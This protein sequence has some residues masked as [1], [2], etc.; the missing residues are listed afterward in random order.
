MLFM[1]KGGGR[2]YEL[3]FSNAGQ[4]VKGDQVA[5]AG[6]PIGSVKDV[7]LTDDGL[8]KITISSDR[9]LHEGTTAI[10]RATSLSGISNHYIAIEPGPNNRPELSEG[11]T[12]PADRTTTP[13]D[14]D[15]LFNTFTPGTRQALRE[16]INGSATLY[17]GNT[18]G[19]RATYKYLAP[20][21]SSTQRLF[22]ELTRDQSAF[23]QFLVNSADVLGA[24]ATRRDDLSSLVANANRSLGAIASQ[25]QALSN[26]LAALPPTLRQAN[27]TFVNL[28]L[29]LDKLDP[30]VAA[31]KPATKNLAPFL[32]KLRPVARR[33]V[34]V[35]ADLSRAVHR[36]GASNDLTDTLRGLPK[37]E[38][39][40]NN[41]VPRII[42]ALDASQPVV[43]FAR[44][45]MP[46]VLGSLTKLGEVTAYYDANGHYARVQPTGA[47]LFNWVPSTSLLDPIP[48]TDQFNAFDTGIF[49]RCPGAATQPIPGSNPFLDNGNLA[50]E[51]DPSNVPPG[52]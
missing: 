21:L 52:P 26:S 10:I 43:T 40:A 27:T 42:D 9:P 20:S 19:A 12:I 37:A 30:L 47:N 34:P 25:N 3:I 11:A 5:V 17:A 18:K 31:A 2:T 38:S 15:Q 24:V 44:P 1:S 45:Y 29:T 48:L 22:A 41:A 46:D 49:T 35:T 28:R 13:V 39:G 7:T 4:L 6:Q 23:S 8:A 51:C 14:L 50:G 32:K 36:P 33:A 16:V